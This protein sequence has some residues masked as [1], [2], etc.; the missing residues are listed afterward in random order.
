[1]ASEY[2]ADA[3]EDRGDEGVGLE[4]VPEEHL[5]R[6]Q[7]QAERRAEHGGDPR[8]QHSRSAAVVGSNRPTVAPTATPMCMIGPSRPPDPPQESVNVAAIP[9]KRARPSH[10]G[11]PRDA[12]SMGALGVSGRAAPPRDP[13]RLRGSSPAYHRRKTDAVNRAPPF[14]VRIRGTGGV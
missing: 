5:G 11:T 4:V 2:E 13:P 14:P 9:F 3:G 8:D 7:R 12:E 1:M 6:E 10:D